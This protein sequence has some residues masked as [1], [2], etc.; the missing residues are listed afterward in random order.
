MRLGNTGLSSVDSSC[1][2]VTK[3]EWSQLRVCFDFQFLYLLLISPCVL[4]GFPV[5]GRGRK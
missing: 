3:T 1:V 5:K 4:D 2:S